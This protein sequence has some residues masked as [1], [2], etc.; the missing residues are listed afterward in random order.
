RP[1][2]RRVPYG[3]HDVA[4]LRQAGPTLR[5]APPVLRQ[6]QHEGST[7]ARA[8][9]FIPRDLS[10]PAQPPS[11]RAT[12]LIL[13][14]VPHPEL[15]EGRARLTLATIPEFRKAQPRMRSRTFRTLSS[16]PPCFDRL[17]MRGAQKLARLLSPRA[18]SL[19]LSLSKDERR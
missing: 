2:H 12:S 7:K 11:S 18:T 3:E 6:S 10:H 1:C 8:T 14:N 9:S 13:R 4:A 5:S 16:A 15:V 17:S 19:I